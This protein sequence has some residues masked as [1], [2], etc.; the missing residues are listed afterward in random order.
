[1]VDKC[2]ITIP[3]KPTIEAELKKPLSNAITAVYS[4][5]SIQDINQ[6]LDELDKLRKNAVC[7][8]LDRHESSLEILYKYYDQLH[9]LEMKLPSAEHQIPFK[10]K[11][12]FDK[13]GLFVGRM[14][15]TQASL[16]FEKICVMFNI[17]AMLSQIGAN[18]NVEFDDGLKT[19]TKYF[20]Q[21]AGVFN[22]VKDHVLAAI[23]QDPTPDLY[24]DCLSALITLMTAQAQEVLF[25][26]ATKEKM[27][28]GVIA[29]VAAQTEDYYADAMKLM[30]RESIRM[31]WEKDWL[32][33]IACKQAGY[34]A[35][36]EYYQ[37]LVHKANKEVGEE[38]ARL[39]QA[40]ELI[41][42]ARKKYDTPAFPFKYA[43]TIIQRDYDAAR[44]DNDF[45]YHARVPDMKSLQPIGRA[46]L[47]K[48][49]LPSFPLSDKFVDLFGALVPVAIQ[50]ATTAHNTRKQELVNR[51]VANLR[52]QTQLMN[53]LLASLNLPAALEDSSGVDVPESVRQKAANI[54]QEGG[55]DTLKATMNSLPDML[56]RNK[57][58]LNECDRLLQEELTSDEQLKSQ[59]GQRWNRMPSSQLSEPLRT[60]SAKY[61][62][63]VSN[64]EKADAIV[65]DKFQKHERAM[66]LLSCS[67]QELVQNVPSANPVKGLL[68]SPV[69]SKLRLLLDTVDAIKLTRENAENDLKAAVVEIKPRLLQEPSMP[70]DAVY[71]LSVE[72][73]NR[74]LGP[75]QKSI[76]ETFTLQ[77]TIMPEI[78][79]LNA[80]FCQ[81][82]SANK[83]AEQRETVLKDLAAAYDAFMELKANLNEG[84]KFYGDLTELLLKFQSKIG[85]FCFARNAEKEELLRAVQ[86]NII[87]KPTSDSG[88]P[89]APSFHEG[90]GGQ[91]KTAPP[92][93]PPPPSSG[94]G[95][96]A[97]GQPTNPPPNATSSPPSYPPHQGGMPPGYP[98]QNYPNQG[99]NPYAGA[100]G[101]PYPAFG[102]YN[103]PSF[104][105]NMAYNMTYPGA[106]GQAYP[107]PPAP[108]YP[109]QNP[110][111]PGY[112]PAQPGMEHW[113][114]GQ[115][116]GG[117]RP[118]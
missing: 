97:P 39:K 72:E 95:A 99:Y 23:Q 76:H 36:A 101:A 59:F 1:M 30:Q 98:P 46:P 40:L 87:N 89:K 112:P 108:A 79:Q 103:P 50:Q 78:Q 19:A 83:S 82:K 85:D 69:V 26:K 43:E 54:K 56:Q 18:Q 63:I 21:A 86:A 2:F 71:A 16:G 114:Q 49:I 116:Q 53:A 61:R 96:S 33:I 110:Y 118:S 42:Y 102:A 60:E 104:N 22:Y 74:V 93:R 38:V 66:Y 47:A 115:Q 12:A 81:Q 113:Q 77:Q 41:Q 88:V 92:P 32:N 57:D 4:G 34:H 48:P 106:G 20:Q 27:K 67:D 13:G 3:T 91:P 37:A 7:R 28:D 8:I 10:W 52:E 100:P 84:A 55:L 107:Y 64:A 24:P 73:L 117:Y 68:S 65:R 31:C 11:D 75:I 6:S 29:K 105:P 58:I 15:L 51:E 17:G 90:D 70:A 62:A 80:E 111:P 35:I 45:I 5:E 14:S 25:M 94:P 44:K 109:Y 9:S